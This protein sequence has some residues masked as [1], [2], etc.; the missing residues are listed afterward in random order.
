MSGLDPGDG[1][2]EKQR[3]QNLHSAERARKWVHF[4]EQPRTTARRWQPCKLFCWV[5]WGAVPGYIA[6]MPGPRAFSGILVFGEFLTY[7]LQSWI[8]PY[9]AKNSD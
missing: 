1:D 5:I 6:P 2:A 4:S 9:M 3:V 8:W 7:L